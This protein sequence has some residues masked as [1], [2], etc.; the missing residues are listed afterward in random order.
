MLSRPKAKFIFL[1]SLLTYGVIFSGTMVEGQT[2][3]IKINP[4]AEVVMNDIRLGDIAEIKCPKWQQMKRLGDILIAP[5]PSYGKSR[6]IRHDEVIAKLK[7]NNVDPS[8]VIFDSPGEIIVFR[9]VAQISKKEIE[10]KIAT[11]IQKSNWWDNDNITLKKVQIS[12][13]VV[14]PKG[15]ISY[16][17]GEAVRLDLGNPMQVPV[18]ITVDDIFT[19]KLNV[20]VYKELFADVVVVTNMLRRYQLITEDDITLKRMNVDEL[21]SNIILDPEEVLG[22]RTKRAIYPKTVLRADLVE[23][24][25]II[26]RKDI[27]TIMAVSGKLKVTALGEAMERGR[28]G[29]RIRVVNTD[30]GEKVIARVL[31]PKTVRIEF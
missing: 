28:Q 9:S 18:T 16:L 3:Q 22:K 23:L 7:Q 10:A 21:S 13:N 24:P 29:D 1:I 4:R 15:N 26:K 17:I 14:L 20:F 12:D 5:A 19:K 27:V 11:E 31:N 2:F 30:S 8:N 6:S 25:P